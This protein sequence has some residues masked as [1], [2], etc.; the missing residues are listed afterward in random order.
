MGNYFYF[1]DT[2]QDIPVGKAMGYGLDG[3]GSILR[4]LSITHCLD[5][6]WW[7]TKPSIEWA[8]RALSL[9]GRAARA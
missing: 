7:T 2:S 3:L 6:L 5:L 9:E 8:V 4:F 1:Y